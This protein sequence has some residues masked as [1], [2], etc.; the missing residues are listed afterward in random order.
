MSDC[1]KGVNELISKYIKVGWYRLTNIFNRYRIAKEKHI[2]QEVD[3]NLLKL[4]GDVRMY[5]INRTYKCHQTN[6]NQYMFKTGST[7]I[8]SDLD[9]NIVGKNCE[10]TM[11][12]M[13]DSF[14]KHYGNILSHSFDT[15]IYVHGFFVSEDSSN[16]SVFKLSEYPDKDFYI[17]PLDKKDYDINIK[18]AC[19][20]LL[21]LNTTPYE[22]VHK[23]VVASM[24]IKKKLEEVYKNKKNVIKK[25]YPKMPNNNIDVI[26]KY[27]ILYDYSHILNNQIY[28]KKDTTDYTTIANICK[29]FSIESYYTQ[30]T[31]NVVVLELDKN[32]LNLKLHKIDYLCSAIE[33]LADFAHHMHRELRYIKNEEDFDMKIIKYSKYLYRIYYSLYKAHTIF[34]LDLHSQV[35]NIKNGILK[36]RN[37]PD[38]S[39]INYKLLDYDKNFYKGNYNKYVDDIINKFMKQINEL[40]K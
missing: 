29:Y 6:K 17:I 12:K 38:I 11:I 40:L 19:M 8:T 2:K 36:Y 31:F 30:S 33:N 4:L 7:N 20:K 27:N 28:N 24:D 23:Y 21:E 16:K 9:V 10:S 15:N 13:F 35:I 37:S 34:K 14:L 39:R 1:G 32:V 26:T 18:F 3:E 25:K 22:T 5:I